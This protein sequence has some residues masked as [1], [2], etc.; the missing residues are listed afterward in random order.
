[1]ITVGDDRAAIWWDGAHWT[2]N[3]A[4]AYP[5]TDWHEA[6]A[7]MEELQCSSGTKHRTELMPVLKGKPSIDDLERMIEGPAPGIGIL[8]NGEVVAHPSRHVSASVRG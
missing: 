3:P 1:M 6:K 7:V 4:N 5:Y 2:Y 8:P